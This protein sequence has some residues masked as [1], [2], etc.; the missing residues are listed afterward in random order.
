MNCLVKR[1]LGTALGLVLVL[2]W[3]TVRDKVFGGGTSAASDKI[4]AKVWE[5]GGTRLT[6]ETESSD[7][8]VLRAFFESTAKNNGT[9][10]RS[11]DS[12]EKMPAGTHSWTIDVPA[13]VGG[14]LE[15]EAQNPKAGSHLTWTVRSGNTVL[16]HETETLDGALRAN[17]AF[18]LKVDAEDFSRTDS[19][20]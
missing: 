11:L 2:G 8:V 3:W 9:P 15:L 13:T 16:K 17:E 10:L 20:E 5:G 1:A 7:P 18:F 19:D 6:I 12:Y 14:D 4:P